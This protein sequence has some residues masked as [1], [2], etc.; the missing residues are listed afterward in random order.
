MPLCGAVLPSCLGGPLFTHFSFICLSI[1]LALSLWAECTHPSV[2]SDKV[3]V[4]I[5]AL[6]LIMKTSMAAPSTSPLLHHRH[7]QA[8]TLYTSAFTLN[9]LKSHFSLS[10]S[11]SRTHTHTHTISPSKYTLSFLP[12]RLSSLPRVARVHHRCRVSCVSL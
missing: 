9:T 8:S 7:T 4:F 12:R 6:P 1:S 3:S 2:K 11:L 5:W 10:L